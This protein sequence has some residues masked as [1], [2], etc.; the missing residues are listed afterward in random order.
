[1]S[2][3]P[4]WPLARVH[5]TVSTALHQWDPGLL[6]LYQ[7]F[8]T[9]LAV[10][11]IHILFYT[12]AV[13]TTLFASLATAFISLARDEG[14]RAR[15]QV[16]MILT[17]G[18]MCLLGSVATTVRS[19]EVAVC[20][21]LSIVAFAAFYVRKFLMGPGGFSLFLFTFTLLS[22]ALPVNLRTVLLASP[23]GG[24]VAFVVTFW[25]V[26]D[27]DESK[28]VRDGVRSVC[29]M[30]ARSISATDCD[31][32]FA[33]CEED[34][35]FT[36]L[37]FVQKTAARSGD[38]GAQQ[39]VA[40]LHHLVHACR[41]LGTAAV[42]ILCCDPNNSTA[43]EPL[44]A[45]TAARLTSPGL[46]RGEAEIGSAIKAMREQLTPP[47]PGN[48]RQVPFLVFLV[49]VERANGD[50][51]HLSADFGLSRSNRQASIQ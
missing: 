26:P 48:S 10:G 14:S 30:L 37:S 4:A 18:A 5:A 6:R 7:A 41:E 23:A 28:A 31:R 47:E 40:V 51:D 35:L 32:G 25:I 24:L 9:I 21:L 43:L 22:A 15:Q 12:A 49:S 44:M 38:S 2:V 33:L 45:A 50:M 36:T 27:R 39:A 46:D 17:T 29:K 34:L 8:R 42:S 3:T 1:M 19:S 20:I 13:N 16:I 11:L